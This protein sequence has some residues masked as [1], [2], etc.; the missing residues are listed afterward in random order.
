MK[1]KNAM[2]VLE[3]IEK[4]LMKPRKEGEN[5][6]PLSPTHRKE[7][8]QLRDRNISDIKSRL[9]NIKNIKRDEFKLK[10]ADK[11]QKQTNI[12]KQTTDDLNDK[13]R[14][15][16]SKIN[17]HISD[18]KEL[19]ENYN[20]EN[21]R[22]DSEYSDLA[23]LK[24]LTTRRHYDVNSEAVEKVISG[25]FY[26]KFNDKFEEVQNQINLLL[27]RYEEAINFGDLEIVKEIYY[28]LKQADVYLNK[29]SSIKV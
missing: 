26:D 4:R 6:F 12:I 8:R 23:N 14:I 19:Q 20:L 13:W 7:L 10:Y 9:K 21:I 22:I 2:V 17:E 16:L 24:F 25:L 28:N 18:F 27:E 15:T 1:E 3:N 5:V 11:I 29:V